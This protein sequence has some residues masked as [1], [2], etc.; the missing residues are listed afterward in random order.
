MR[1]CWCLEYYSVRI[2]SWTDASFVCSPVPRVTLLELDKRAWTLYYIIYILICIPIHTY[3]GIYTYPGGVTVNFTTY[4]S[5]LYMANNLCS[6]VAKKSSPH[7]FC[8]LELAG[9]EWPLISFRQQLALFVPVF[10]STLRSPT[11]L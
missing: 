2:L 6:L 11:I 10:L 8:W 5:D 7:M 4:P 3:I 1:R 9:G